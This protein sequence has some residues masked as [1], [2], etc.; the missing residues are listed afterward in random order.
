MLG[1]AL[2][3]VAYARGLKKRR[4]FVRFQFAAAVC[5]AFLYAVSDEFHQSFVPGRTPSAW[6]VCIDTAGAIIGLWLWRLI[7]A[8][9]LN[10]Q[11]AGTN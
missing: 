10:P 8:R 9:R 7:Q 4:A 1:Y 3:A 11:E 2:L 6:D 5:L